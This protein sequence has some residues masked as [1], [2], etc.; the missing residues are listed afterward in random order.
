MPLVHRPN[1]RLL[2]HLHDGIHHLLRRL[3]ELHNLPGL[4]LRAWMLGERRLDLVQNRGEVCGL[5]VR[6]T[7]A[8]SS[9]HP[10]PERVHG[11]EEVRQTI[12][13]IVGATGTAMGDIEG[14][15]QH[16]KS[17]LGRART[18][19]KVEW[20]QHKSIRNA[21][22]RAPAQVWVESQSRDWTAAY[23]SPA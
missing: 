20:E 16:L 9:I 18:K 14:R 23:P 12:A 11:A 3:Y 13:T 1:L 10:D 8:C 21:P 7:V 2:T 22:R 15:S 4:S 5:P 6:T 19:Q 17:N